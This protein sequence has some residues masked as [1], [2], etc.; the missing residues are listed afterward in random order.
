MPGIEPPR[1]EL[2]GPP[3]GAGGVEVGDA[4]RLGGIEHFMGVGFQGRRIG[5]LCQIVTMSQVDV[6]GP[7][8]GRQTQTDH[9]DSEARCSQRSVFH[10]GHPT[11]PAPTP[12]R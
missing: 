12:K 2:L 11:L 9:R 4:G 8:Q 3:I 1:Q 7:P 10:T 6:T 5:S